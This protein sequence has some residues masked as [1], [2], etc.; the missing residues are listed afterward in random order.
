MTSESQ[1]LTKLSEKE[2]TYLGRWAAAELHRKDVMPHKTL[3]DCLAI[4]SEFKRRG[5]VELWRAIWKGK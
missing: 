5:L 2:L 3:K 4:E 1:D